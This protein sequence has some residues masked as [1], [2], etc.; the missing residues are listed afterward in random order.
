MIIASSAMADNLSFIV[1]VLPAASLTHPAQTP[2]TKAAIGARVATL[3]RLEGIQ[4]FGGD[5]TL[6]GVLDYG[7][8]CH[9]GSFAYHH[10][11]CHFAFEG[12]D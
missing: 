3:R 11:H 6:L 2:S 7:G 5:S 10:H 9:D 4:V 1:A 12:I 8:G